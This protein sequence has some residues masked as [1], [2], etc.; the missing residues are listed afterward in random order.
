VEVMTTNAIA[1]PGD[2]SANPGDLLRQLTQGDSRQVSLGQTCVL[3]PYQQVMGQKDK[4][5]KG[6]NGVELTGKQGVDVKDL[7]RLTEEG[8]SQPFIVKGNQANH[9]KFSRWQS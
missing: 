3:D 4:A 2:E 5:Q 8:L 6:F 7:A 1:I 9:P